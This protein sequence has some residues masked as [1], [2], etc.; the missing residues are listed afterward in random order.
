[1]SGTISDININQYQK[2]L[3]IEMEIVREVVRADKHNLRKSGN[4]KAQDRVHSGHY[5][6]LCF[7]NCRFS[8]AVFVTSNNLTRNLLFYFQ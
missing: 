2:Q 6:D 3:E 1:M 4:C 7:A 5:T 8:Q